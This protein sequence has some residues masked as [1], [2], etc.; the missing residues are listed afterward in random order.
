MDGTSLSREVCGLCSLIF[1]P[2]YCVQNRE[3][4]PDAPHGLHKHVDHRD[5]LLVRNTK[6]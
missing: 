4:I 2:V 3:L 6:K 5:A 1:W